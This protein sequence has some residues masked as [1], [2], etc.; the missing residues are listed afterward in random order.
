MLDIT[1]GIFTVFSVGIGGMF[2]YAAVAQH[3]K[4]TRLRQTGIVT[5]GVVVR[6]EKDN[7][8]ESSSLYPV[9]RFTALNRGIVTMRHNFGSQPAGFHVGQQ[10]QILYDPSAPEEFVIGAGS[11]DWETLVLGLIGA[12]LL[13][14]GLYG[15]IKPYV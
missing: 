13:G 9:I 7:D 12:G 6:L 4:R 8:P 10:V 3:R 11:I 5:A 2:E 14:V 1:A 15:C